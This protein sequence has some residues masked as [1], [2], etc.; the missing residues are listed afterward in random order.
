MLKISS[1]LL[2]TLPL[3]C[4]IGIVLALQTTINSQLREYLHSPLQA[5]LFSFLIGTIVLAVC[6]YFESTHRPTWQ[7]LQTIP[8]YLYLGGVCGVYAISMSI[9][10]APKIGLLT[11]SGLI[12]FG[13]LLMSMLIDHTGWLGAEKFA[14]NWQ[15]LLGGVV[16]FIGVLLTLQR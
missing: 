4:L 5:A 11:L 8:W 13:Q 2:F 12:I 16:I 9:Y 10:S 1:Q 3:V 6:V 14:L 15:R 7:M